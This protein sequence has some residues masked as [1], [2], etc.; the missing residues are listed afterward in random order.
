MMKMV[1]YQ[2][3]TPEKSWGKTSLK[4]QPKFVLYSTWSALLRTVKLIENKE[5]LRNDYS[6]EKPKET[7]QSMQCA[8]LDGFWNEKK[9]RVLAKN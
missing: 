4:P 2:H 7:W 1:L 9:K 5:S 8:I 6:Q 3:I